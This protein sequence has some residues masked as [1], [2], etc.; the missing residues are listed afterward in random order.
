MN[1]KPK[2]THMTD[3]TERWA[4]GS[5]KNPVQKNL[6]KL[7][8]K[9]ALLSYCKRVNEN[10]DYR[11]TRKEWNFTLFEWH[12]IHSHSKRVKFHSKEFGDVTDLTDVNYHFERDTVVVGELG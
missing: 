8:K 6:G 7:A 1:I 5:E 2:Q 9:S 10:S 4:S 11:F 3:E 12:L